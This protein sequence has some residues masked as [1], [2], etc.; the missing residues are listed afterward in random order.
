[1]PQYR[2][3]LYNNTEPLDLEDG[4]NKKLLESSKR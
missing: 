2:A 3:S 1:M 4:D